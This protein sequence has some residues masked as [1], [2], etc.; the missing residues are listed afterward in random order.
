[1]SPVRSRLCTSH[2]FVTPLESKIIATSPGFGIEPG[3]HAQYFP[4][5]PHCVRVHRVKS[6]VWQTRPPWTFM[7]INRRYS[8]G[9][10]APWDD[11]ECDRQVRNFSRQKC[12]QCRAWRKLNPQPPDGQAA[13]R[14]E[15]RTCNRRTNSARSQASFRPEV[16]ILTYLTFVGQEYQSVS[17][18][19]HYSSSIAVWSMSHRYAPAHH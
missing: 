19:P 18:D 3:S 4:S 2:F 16:F 6:F 8:T 15:D 7:R 17:N 5:K 12:L 13:A 11:I 10:L 9:Q 1:M 14:R